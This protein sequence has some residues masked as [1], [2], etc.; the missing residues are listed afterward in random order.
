MLLAMGWLERKVSICWRS[1]LSRCLFRTEFT[2]VNLILVP[3]SP[4]LEIQGVFVSVLFKMVGPDG[5]G[6]YGAPMTCR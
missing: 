3:E 6:D 2:H 1:D 5:D 4:N